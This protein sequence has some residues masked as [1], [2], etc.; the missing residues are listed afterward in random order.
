[1]TLPELRIFYLELGLLVIARILLKKVCNCN[2]M[3]NP[4]IMY[5]FFFLF[6]VCNLMV[7]SCTL[8]IWVPCYYFF[9][10]FV[11]HIHLHL[12]IYIMNLPL[13]I[14]CFQEINTCAMLSHG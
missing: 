2:R 8:F 3:M 1:M 12:P 10:S 9:F 6:V 11:C 5:I 13:G 14:K 7:P 4:Y